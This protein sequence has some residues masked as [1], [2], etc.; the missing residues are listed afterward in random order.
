MVSLSTVYAISIALVSIAGFASA[1][2]G[3]LIHNDVQPEP[4]SLSEEFPRTS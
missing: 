2:A 3:F 4:P 1:Y